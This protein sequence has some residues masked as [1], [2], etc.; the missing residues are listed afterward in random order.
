[1]LQTG[2]IAQARI[3]RT[4][5]FLDRPEFS[6]PHGDTDRVRYSAAGARSSARRNENDRQRWPAVSRNFLQSLNP[7]RLAER[8]GCEVLDR[9]RRCG[10]SRAAS[11]NSTPSPIPLPR[12]FSARCRIRRELRCA[13]RRCRNANNG[14]AFTKSQLQPKGCSVHFVKD[15]RLAI[16][17]RPVQFIQRRGP[18]RFTSA[19]SRAA[20]LLD[21]KVEQIRTASDYSETTA[22][23]RSIV[24]VASSSR[25]KDIIDPHSDCCLGFYCEETKPTVGIKARCPDLHLDQIQSFQ[26]SSS[27]GEQREFAR[28]VGGWRS[29]N[30][31]AA[32][33]RWPELDAL[34]ASLQHRFR[35][36]WVS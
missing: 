4:S 25:E 24:S 34:F 31:S 19:A 33:G 30:D 32:R 15:S 17:F 13:P 5:R 1:V 12:L 6:S 35:G 20:G 8:G 11:P 29:L 21:T 7:C 2:K 16:G 27:M 18:E 10:P 14:T 9:A 22:S 3:G 28:R 36:V 23:S 26:S